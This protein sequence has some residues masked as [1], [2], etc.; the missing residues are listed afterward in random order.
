MIQDPE[1]GEAARRFLVRG[2]VQGVGYRAFVWREA[3]HLGLSGWV[4]NRFDGSVEVVVRGPE[5]QLRTL[6]TLLQEGPPWSE[7]DFVEEAAI[8]PDP[9]LSGFS[10]RPTA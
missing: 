3:A 9:T 10:V 7:V 1:P 5:Q 6:K 2:R 4:R 8:E